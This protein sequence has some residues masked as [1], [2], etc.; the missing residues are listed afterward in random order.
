MALQIGLVGLPNVGKS[1]LFNALTNAGALVASYPF[2]TIDPNVGVVP[3]PDPRLGRIAEI[4]AP[5]EAVATTLRVVDIAGLVEG[6]SHGEGLGNQFLGHI[7]NVDAVAMV[8][9]CFQDPEVP[10][11]TA[12][13]DPGEDAETIVDLVREIRGVGV[14][15][16]RPTI[17]AC[18]MIAK[19]LARRGGHAQWHDSD[20]QLVC[21]DV[22]STDT[23]KVSRDGHPVMLDKVEEIMRRAGKSRTRRAAVRHRKGAKDAGSNE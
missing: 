14:S 2:T 11:V 4:V 13:L 8:V 5:E 22:L 9:R 12:T 3:V 10:H 18:M 15:N 23:A 6:A 16:N 20:F 17:R 7:R 1:T 19:V 21:R